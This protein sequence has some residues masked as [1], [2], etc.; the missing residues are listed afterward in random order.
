MDHLIIASHG[1]FA[2]G[3]A[4]GIEILAGSP[5]DIRVIDAFV[6]GGNDICSPVNTTLQDIPSQDR[7][8]VATDLLGGSVNNEFIKVIQ[9]RENVYLV[10][11]M[12][13]PLLITLVLSMDSVDDLDSFLRD[14]VQSNDV[15][16][17]YCNDLLVDV[18]EDEDF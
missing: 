8:V 18:E 11:N 7:V 5:L 10:T 6:D 17:V 15:R 16:P 12:N 1:S 4:Q 9:K 13:L 3:I 14:L 2:S